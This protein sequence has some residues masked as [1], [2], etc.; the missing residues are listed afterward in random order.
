[1]AVS[2]ERAESRMFEFTLD[3]SPDVHRIPLAAY[4]PYPFVKRMKSMK[5]S[6]L[7]FALIDEFCPEL[8]EDAS[9][10]LTTVRAIEDAWDKA[11]REDGADSG[12]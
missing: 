9:L 11:S 8:S 2:I 3:G 4:L 5:L 1:M 6:D 7:A 10:D 12:K